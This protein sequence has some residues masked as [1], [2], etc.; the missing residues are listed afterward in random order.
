MSDEYRR[1]LHEW[2]RQQLETHTSHTGPFVV[3]EV[4][5]EWDDAVGTYEHSSAAV[6]IVFDHS[7]CTLSPR[8]GSDDLTCTAS[9]WTMEGREMVDVLNEL[10]RIANTDEAR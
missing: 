6:G 7:G 10:F 3:R 8:F 2:A 4:C 1:V 9:Y 5:M